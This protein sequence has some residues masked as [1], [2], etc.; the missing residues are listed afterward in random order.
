MND[1]LPSNVKVVSASDA[2]VGTRDKYI[3]ETMAEGIAHVS[4]FSKTKGYGFAS[5]GVGVY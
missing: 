2:F 1:S 5:P 3:D 4:F